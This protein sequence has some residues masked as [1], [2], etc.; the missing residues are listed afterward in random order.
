MAV[1][2]RHACSDIGANYRGVVLALQA[3]V[4]VEIVVDVAAHEQFHGPVVCKHKGGWGNG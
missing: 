2:S 1:G 4:Q 3:T